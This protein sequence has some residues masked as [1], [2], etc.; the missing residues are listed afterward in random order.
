[1]LNSIWGARS[2]M[3]NMEI[4]YRKSENSHSDSF[5]ILND[6][7]K[8]VYDNTMLVLIYLNW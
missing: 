1:M 4:D 8:D 5:V 3:I 6:I 7:S 2:I